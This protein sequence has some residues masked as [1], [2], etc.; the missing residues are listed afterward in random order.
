MSDEGPL[1]ICFD[2]S[3]DSRRAI[4][5]AGALMS[6]RPALVVTGWRSLAGLMLRADVDELSGTMR[7]A[8]D[9]VDATYGEDGRRTAEE[10]AELARSLGLEAEAEVARAGRRIWPKLLELADERHAALIVVGERGVSGIDTGLLGSVAHGVL[11][12][13]ERPVLLTSTRAPDDN[14]GRVLLC[15]DGSEAAG[16]AIGEAGRQFGGREADVVTAWQAYTRVAAAGRIGA[17]D[18]VVQTASRRLEDE[19]ERRAL[20]VAEEG[21]EEARR[22]G[23]TGVKAI[24]HRGD[25][26]VWASLVAAVEEQRPA[27]AVIG[28][29]GRSA[30]RSALLGSVS[31]G[32]A[33]NA[34]VPVLVVPPGS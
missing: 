22:Q 2:G 31:R 14:S 29:R 6:G 10:G 8:A 9:E 13:S 15:Y 1:F 33:T 34:S 19:S 4:A 16:R 20:A 30:I 32:V 18:D 12:H 24:A 27:A 25:H 28:S 5:Q 11:H 26:S 23:F 7:E 17:P 21:A 3:E